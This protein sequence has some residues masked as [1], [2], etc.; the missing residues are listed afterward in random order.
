[1]DPQSPALWHKRLGHV[2][3]RSLHHLVKRHAVS[4]IHVS[5]QDLAKHAATPC[6][7][8]IMAKHNRAP[9]AKHLHKP[10]EPLH[11]LSSDLCGPYQVETLNKCVYVLTLVDWCTRYAAVCLLQNKSDAFKELKRLITQ[12]EAHKGTKVKFLFS[13]RGGEY[14]AGGLK[15]WCAEKGT[16]HDFSVPHTPQ[17]NG[18]AERLNQTLHNMV[19]AM[20]LQYKTY[21]PLWGDAMMYA[22]RIKNMS[23]NNDLGMTPYEAFH[24]HVPDVSNFRVFGCLAFGRVPDEGR[25]KLAPKSVPGIYLGPELNGPGYRVLVYKPEYKRAC[26]YNVEIFRDIVCL[27]EGNTIMGASDV[28]KLHWGGH[29]ELPKPVEV[30]EEKEKESS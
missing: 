8:C 27:E 9:H 3:L 4:G 11:T 24:G 15:I 7:V 26:K 19:R 1:M 30:P 12:W 20:M 29:I 17:Q 21:A 18:V 16:V 14:I 25:P 13:D 28:I 5:A 6:E 2:P 22:V 23:L 10:V